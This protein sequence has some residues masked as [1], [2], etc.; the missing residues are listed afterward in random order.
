MA[1]VPVLSF[2]VFVQA[3]ALICVLVSLQVPNFLL[4]APVLLVSIAGCWAYAQRNARHM[5]LGGLSHISSSTAATTG[6][7]AARPG[8][9]VTASPASSKRHQRD[10][11]VRLYATGFFSP[12]VAVFIYPWAF[13]AAC[14]LLIMHVQVRMQLL[15][16]FAFVC[17]LKQ[18]I[19]F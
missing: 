3:H 11:S 6:S 1:C 16:Q 7:T 2:E 4:A 8:S 9:T 10:G 12:R 14:A 19:R 13:M 17:E 5:A 15:M 18:G